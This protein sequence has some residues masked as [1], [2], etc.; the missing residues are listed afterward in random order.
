MRPV[1][2]IGLSRCVEYHL[3]VRPKPLEKGVGLL[4]MLAAAPVARGAAGNLSDRALA[5]DSVVPLL[6]QGVD[7]QN[8][9]WVNVCPVDQRR[10]RWPPR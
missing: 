3:V 2:L 6:L 9:I 10:K 7:R 1:S 8:E 5:V 4:P